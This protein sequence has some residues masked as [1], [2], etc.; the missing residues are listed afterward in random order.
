MRKQ[1]YNKKFGTKKNMV[2]RQPDD[3]LEYKPRENAGRP[4]REYEINPSFQRKAFKDLAFNSIT[5]PV[6]PSGETSDQSDPYAIINRTNPVVDA[7]YPGSDNTSGS[8]VP[9]LAEASDSTFNNM[10][11]SV[12]QEIK[13]NLYYCKTNANSNA[14]YNTSTTKGTVNV[15]M[16]VPYDDIINSITAEAYYDLKFFNWVPDGTLYSDDGQLDVLLNYQSVVQTLTNIPLRYRVIRSLE[17]HLKDMSYYNGSERMNR[18][19]GMLKKSSFISLIKSVAESS[20]VHYLDEFWFKQ[21]SMLVAIPCR[22]SNSMS[23]PLIDIIPTYDINTTLKVYPDSTKTPGKE[24][25]DMS[26]FTAIMTNARDFMLHTSPQYLLSMARSSSYSINMVNTW[27]NGLTNNLDAIIALLPEF[28]NQFADLL[29]A[30]KRMAKVG[31]TEWKTGFFVDVDGIDQNYQPKFNKLIFDIVRASFTGSTTYSYVPRTGQWEVH[32]LWDK[33]LGISTYNYK[34]GGCILTT[35][36]RTITKVGAPVNASVPVLFYGAG[37]DNKCEMTVLTRKGQSYIIKGERSTKINTGA[38]A[39]VLGRLLPI[40]ALA[41]DYFIIPTCDVST[42]ATDPRQQGWIID[43][44]TNLF[45]YGQAVV[46][47]NTYNYFTS[48]DALCFVDVEIA[49]Q[50]NAVETFVRQHSPFRVLKPTNDAVLGFYT[51]K[52][53]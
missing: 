25:I 49:D 26:D 21:T 37:V 18:I 31:I 46:A 53:K 14:D 23:D 24:I 43:M 16:D 22:K 35:S 41:D 48:P 52:G 42:L 40:D 2:K 29:V 30:F 6:D 33:Y 34:T 27:I 20:M 47:T 39:R 28:R 51:S 7:K 44:M 45:G 3:N 12:Q 1:K 17:K 13:L 32:D 8:I 5:V 19:F 4:E 11:D 38:I 36:T 10:P 50:T 15:K 9:Q